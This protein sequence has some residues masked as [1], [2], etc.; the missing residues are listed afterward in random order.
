MST[1][2]NGTGARRRLLVIAL[3]VAS[4]ATVF[5]LWPWLPWSEHADLDTLYEF[6]LDVDRPLAAPVAVVALFTLSALLFL[7]VTPLI[8]AAMLA[9]DPW[10]GGVWSLAGIMVAGQVAFAL[11]RWLGRSEVVRLRH[12]TVSDAARFM[13]E[14]G[15]LKTALL[16]LVP[17]AHFNV[18]SFA[19]GISHVRWWAYSV[20]TAL[21]SAIMLIIVALVYERT[22]AVLARPTPGGLVVLVVLTLLVLLALV[23][24]QRSGRRLA[25]RSRQRSHNG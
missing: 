4:L 2:P 12:S 20:G 15:M 16:R 11:G 17:V 18:V 1:P 7:P 10:W 14:H 9:L 22:S 8:L 23:L 21:G 19:L 3:V 25:T 6:L 24:L 13:R 5:S